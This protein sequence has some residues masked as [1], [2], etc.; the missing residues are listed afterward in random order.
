MEIGHVLSTMNNNDLEKL[1]T[2]MNIKKDAIIINQTNEMSFQKLELSTGIYEV[3]NFNEKGVGLS[4]NNGMMRSNFDITLISDDDMEYVEDYISIIED[5]YSVHP[6]AD[7]LVF[8]VRIYEKN[9]MRSPVKKKGRVHF[10]NCLRYGAV[11]FTF[12]TESVKKANIN[13][14]LLFGGGAKYSSGEDAIFIWDCLKAGLK[15]YSVNK[16]IADVY[17]DNSTWFEGH[18]DKYFRDRGVFFAS[19]SKR[20]AKLFCFQ[21]A[22]RKRSIF[23]KNK[24]VLS[25]YKL[26]IQGV[27][28]FKKL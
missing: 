3:Y 14:S 25:T 17:N 23:K 11:T 8:N 24:T 22:L 21:F 13:F 19:I 5:A 12:K 4:R 20:F 10:L 28:D 18:T 26:M 15:I 9:N 16:V 27:R 7:M 1:L 2:K 6:N